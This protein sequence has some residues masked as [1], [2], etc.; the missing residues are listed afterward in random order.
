MHHYKS[1]F[2]IEVLFMQNLASPLFASESSLYRLSVHS[3]HKR[4]NR[5]IWNLHT[6][7]SGSADLRLFTAI[8]I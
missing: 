5:K 2:F 7:K 4:L 8:H 3:E 6:L 1:Y